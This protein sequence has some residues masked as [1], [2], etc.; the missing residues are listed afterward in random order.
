MNVCGEFKW[1]LV[2]FTLSHKA[3]FNWGKTFSEH[4]VRH[5]NKNNSVLLQDIM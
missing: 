3:I 2:V 4:I 1:K 5:T